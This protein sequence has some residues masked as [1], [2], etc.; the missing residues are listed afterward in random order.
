MVKQPPHVLVTTP[1]S[2]Y[3]ILTSE[4]ARD[5]LRNV[6]TV[7]VDGP[8]PRATS[9]ATT[10]PCR[11]AT[12]RALAPPV[13]AH[14]LSATQKPIRR[15]RGSS[16]PSAR[17]PRSSIRGTCGRSIWRSRSPRRRSRR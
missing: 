15:S 6:R 7:I 2:L 14:R 11:R 4:R 1:E 16:G 9:A 17:S 5:M 13:A 8:P 12:G 3:L 10:S